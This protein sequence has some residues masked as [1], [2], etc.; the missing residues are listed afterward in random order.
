MKLAH[1]VLLFLGPLI[2]KYILQYLQH[3][4]YDVWWG[5][6]LA[7]ALMLTNFA[8]AF[9]INA[10]FHTLFRI[11]MHIKVAIISTLYRKS[12]RLSNRAKGEY[13]V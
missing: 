13:G 9:C 12:L 10:Y 5:F 4:E 8:Q 7:L 11:G 6:S 2:L 3:P 1:D